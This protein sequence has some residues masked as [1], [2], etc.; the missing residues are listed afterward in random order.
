M[1]IFALGFENSANNDK[2]ENIFNYIYNSFI[3]VN[4]I[5][6]TGKTYYTKILDDYLT[7]EE[8]KGMDNLVFFKVVYDVNTDNG[9]NKFIINKYV[10]K[11]LYDFNRITD[12]GINKIDEI[13]LPLNIILIDRNDDLNIIRS[14]IKLFNGNIDFDILYKKENE[15]KEIKPLFFFLKK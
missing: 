5:S 3:N 11:S 10:T 15:I 2:I 13:E 1:G 6:F 7:D 8:L 9:F 4:D 14:N 12:I